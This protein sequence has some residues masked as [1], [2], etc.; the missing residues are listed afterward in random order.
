MG[1][2]LR[3]RIAVMSIALA[4]VVV[5]APTVAG[6]LVPGGRIVAPRPA[7]ATLG[8]AYT[9]PTADL[10]TVAN[11]LS[12]RA[13]SVSTVISV[14]AGLALTTPASP[15]HISVKF[16]GVRLP[17]QNY[18]PT[19]G[20]R[21]V[22][23]FPAAD[24]LGHVQYIEIDLDQVKPGVGDLGFP[25]YWNP[26]I[27]PLY[28]VTISPLTFQLTTD[29]EYFGDSHIEFFWTSPDTGSGE[30]L[31][32]TST[33]K[34]VGIP[35]FSGTWTQVSASSKL[36]Q[37]TLSFT[38]PGSSLYNNTIEAYGDFIGAEFTP[39]SVAV[40]PVNLVPGRS[41]VVGHVVASTNSAEQDCTAW[42]RYSE[43]YTLDTYPYL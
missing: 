28:D 22:Y 12:Y 26:M 35:E 3:K 18:N 5:V 37:P 19:T 1:I 15:V 6:A 17:T 43:N 8:P 30:Y 2:S 38:D 36:F 39:G 20:N 40:P 41:N 10:A 7:G 14:P 42:V 25:I 13:K 16:S 33:G 9:G 11:N 21:I 32:T 29:C 23:D 31:F 27:T 34:T 4:A 24:Q